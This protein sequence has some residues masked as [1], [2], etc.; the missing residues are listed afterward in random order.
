LR[1]Y[2]SYNKPKDLE[3]IGSAH[4]RAWDAFQKLKSIF[5]DELER[6]D[7]AKVRA[8]LGRVQKAMG[9]TADAEEHLLQ[10]VK[11]DPTLA[12]VFNDLGAI[13]ASHDDFKGAIEYFERAINIEPHNFGYK[14]N[15]AEAYQKTE[16]FDEAE[17]TYQKLLGIAPSHVDSL[18]GLAE[19]YAAMGDAAL[20]G[21]SSADAEMMF[22]QAIVF[23]T[24]V[25][26]FETHAD[27]SREGEPFEASK[28]IKPR[29]LNAIYY[30]RGYARASLYDA[31]SRKSEILLFQARNDF[32]KV[33]KF[34]ADENFH[35][36]K[37]ALSKIY[38][39]LSPLSSQN[40]EQRTGPIFISFLAFLLFGLSLAAFFIG[41]PELSSPAFVLTDKTSAV[42]KSLDLPQQAVQRIDVLVG[43]EFAN[44]EGLLAAVK[45]LTGEEVYKTYEPILL[46]QPLQAP[47][48]LQWK[49]VKLHS[50][51]LMAFGSLIFMVAGLYLQ[52][53]SKLKFGSI[54]IEKSSVEQI[55]SSGALSIRK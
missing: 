6:N 48:E 50:F 16:R 46:S 45:L 49:P 44:R 14:S 2:Y 3:A 29:E 8:F 26:D 53:I 35:K 42:L 30:S 5:E 17:K 34:E 37:R 7:S 31:Q 33:T 25:I 40:I 21:S 9:E 52:Q 12:N 1:D 28:R 4:W 54:E 41:R 22:K 27:R 43:K 32:R 24:K 13:K 11:L 47:A 51:A 38:E 39:R 18:I 10:A 15:L 19:T 36:A 55:S 20:Q 23:Y